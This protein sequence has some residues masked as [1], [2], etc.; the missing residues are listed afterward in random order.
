MNASLGNPVIGRWEN[1]GKF[2]YKKL[3]EYDDMLSRWQAIS[4]LGVCVD[5]T[6]VGDDQIRCVGGHTL[7]AVLSK[8]IVGPVGK[9]A[10][11]ELLQE[12]QGTLVDNEWAHTDIKLANVVVKYHQT[13]LSD[14]KVMLIDCDYARPFGEDRLVGTRGINMDESNGG[15]CDGDT[16][17][18]GF[19]SIYDAFE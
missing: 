2:Y 6:E 5:F 4:S 8:R 15:I 10:I 14:P 19:S 12:I 16:D 9:Q 13:D 7:E 18:M 1:G 17:K 3:T 11:V